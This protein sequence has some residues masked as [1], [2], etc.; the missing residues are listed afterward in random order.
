F[1][2]LLPDDQSCAPAANAGRRALV[3]RPDARTRPTLRAVLQPALWAYGHAV[4]GPVSLMPR[5]FGALRSCL[6]SVHRTQSGTGR[7][8]DL[9]TVIPLVQSC[10]KYR[11]AG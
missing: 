10:G 4:G 11:H 7:D 9:G 6:L 5:R 3:R 8:G 2:R 1:T